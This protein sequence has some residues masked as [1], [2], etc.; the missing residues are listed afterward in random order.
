MKIRLRPAAATLAALGM[1]TF[2]LPAAA[3][4]SP[5]RNAYFGQT[6]SHT[7][8]SLDAYIIGNHETGPAEA[9]RFSMGEPIKHPAGF[10]VKLKHPLDFHAVTDHSEYMGM[11]R[12]ANDPTSELSK[13]PIAEKLKVGSPADVN[14]VF[15][16]LAGS[17]AKAEPIKELLDPAV[18]GSVWKENVAIADKYYKPGKFTTFVGYEW[19]AAPNN[20]NM[21]R[22]VIFKDSKKVPAMPFTAI[23]FSMFSNMARLPTKMP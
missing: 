5:D 20:R 19:T 3:Q 21:H 14:R 16:W 11:V 9:Y 23:D 7:S 4:N 13:Q 8:W 10:D 12:L 17:L 22:V 1:L 6:H 18:A 15:Q 2:A